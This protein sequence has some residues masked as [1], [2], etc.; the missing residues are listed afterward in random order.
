MRADSE[1]HSFYKTYRTYLEIEKHLSYLRTEYKELIQVATVG[2]SYEN[3]QLY[4]VKLSSAKSPTSNNKESNN[5]IDS[6]SD[7]PIIWIDA[8]HHAREWISHASAMFIMETLLRDYKAGD[9]QIL[10]LFDKYD[11][12]FMPVVNPDGYQYSHDY[13][14]LWRKTRSRHGGGGWLACAGVDPNRNYPTQWMKAGASSN[15]CSEIYG[16]PKPLSEPETYAL[17]Q[18]VLKYK[19]RIKAY[20]SLHSYSQLMLTPWGHSR[21]YPPNYDKLES[22]A[23]VTMK[24]IESIHG[25]HYQFGTSSIILCKSTEE[26]HLINNTRIS[27]I[28]Y[29]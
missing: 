26:I 28:L 13:D 25:T 6:S 11:F 2:R 21:Q 19:S 7:R 27:I 16:G 24:A 4:L 3:R 18:T 15:P 12:Y 10:E 20:L 17:A 22:L 8:G 9:E 23:K 1:P 14:R 5:T 29:L